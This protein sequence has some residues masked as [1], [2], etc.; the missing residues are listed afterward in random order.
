MISATLTVKIRSCDE[1]H[2]PQG[3]KI[4]YGDCSFHSYSKDGLVESTMLFRAK[5]AAAVAIAQ[6]D[7]RTNGVAV[8]YPD[9]EVVDT[10]NGYKE[11]KC[12][13]VIRNFIPTESSQPKFTEKHLQSQPAEHALV[14]AA[15]ASNGISVDELDIP[16]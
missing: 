2:D 7:S 3:V 12:T 4:V 16:F 15:T 5:G 8:G 11:K 9:M 10:G 1:T 13:L 6:F 14:T